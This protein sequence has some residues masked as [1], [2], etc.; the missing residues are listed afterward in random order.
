MRFKWA[1]VC[2]QLE[3]MPAHTCT[4]THTNTA[5][6]RTTKDACGLVS[7]GIRA[8]LL[9]GMFVTQEENPGL[10]SYGKLWSISLTALLWKG[11][12]HLS[13]FLSTGNA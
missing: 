11:L 8:F 4:Y 10:L 13:K 12:H 6:L 2:Q 3:L 7:F 5:G 9:P 1:V